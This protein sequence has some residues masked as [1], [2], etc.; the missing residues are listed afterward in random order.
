MWECFVLSIGGEKGMC[1]WEGPAESNFCLPYNTIV[2]KKKR[3]EVRYMISKS[4]SHYTAK[5]EEFIRKFYTVCLFRL[6]K[7]QMKVGKIKICLFFSGVHLIHDL[8]RV[9][10]MRLTFHRIIELRILHE[11]CTCWRVCNNKNN[12]IDQL[13]LLFRHREIPDERSDLNKTT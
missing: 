4:K 5:K 11:F 13:T 10:W 2:L 12:P 9:K 3:F 7:H 1:T 6:K 8:S